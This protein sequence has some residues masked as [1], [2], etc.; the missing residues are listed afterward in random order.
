M[1]DTQEGVSSTSAE[2]LSEG[3]GTAGNR[4][5]ATEFRQRI[6]NG[7]LGPLPVIVGLAI[8][9]TI[10]AL[11]NHRFLS[12]ENLSNLALQ[13]APVGTM[14]IGIVL[15]LLLGEIDLS[16]G[17]LSGLCGAALG[18]IHVKH[19]VTPIVAIIFA[20]SIA[21]FIGLVQGSV[22][23]RLGI[24]SFVVT[25]AGL[26][27]WQGLQLYVLGRDGTINFSFTGSISKLSNTFLPS[28]VGLGISIALPILAGFIALRAQAERS[29]RGL[30]ISSPVETLAKPVALALVLIGAALVL[31]ADRGVPLPLLI[32]G[33]FVLLVD[34]VLSRTRFGRHVYATG[35]NKEAARR[36]GIPV[37]R[38]RICIFM[39]CS[40]LAATGGVL[41]ASRLA[42][43]NQSSGGSDTLLNAIAAAVIGGTSL[44]GGRGRAYSALLG[45]LVI[46][47]IAN[48]MFLL[49]LDSSVRFMITGAVLLTAVVVD[50]VSRRTAGGLTK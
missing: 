33:G 13:M 21:A 30:P 38:V 7:E 35:G 31:N 28:V 40:M 20:L 10:F 32:F 39:A 34:S 6:R 24:P 25:L 5:V 3:A 49:N 46:T 43:V 18:V 41:A 23:E 9:W 26:I 27:G 42:A 19:G 2:S 29:R 14:S 48:G 36:A 15:V 1:M 47:S 22:I 44:F 50:S 16:A 37:V 4:S 12:P 17:S 11:L 8:I 45:A